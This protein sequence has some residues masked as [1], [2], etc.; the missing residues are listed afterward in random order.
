MSK[1]PY[2]VLLLIGI[3]CRRSEPAPPEPPEQAAARIFDTA[4]N[5]EKDHKTKQAFAAYHQ[6]VQHFPS[7]THGKMAVER[8]RQAQKAAFRKGK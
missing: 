7:T 4:R 6:L 5:L 8:I 2:L 1:V 3:G